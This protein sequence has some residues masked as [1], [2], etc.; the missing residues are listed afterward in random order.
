MPTAL[1]VVPKDGAPSARPI[2]WW[3]SRQ[4]ASSFTQ[5]VTSFGRVWPQKGKFHVVDAPSDS[6]NVNGVGYL[7]IALFDPAGRFVI[8]FGVS[9]SSSDDN[10]NYALRFPQTREL[11]SDFTPNFVFGGATFGTV[12][13]TVR[14]SFYKGPGHSGDI[15]GKLGVV[16]AAD[17][18][19][20]QAIGPGNVQFGTTV[21]VRRGEFSFWAGRVDD[22]VAATR[23]M[24]VTSYVG[25]G[26]ASRNIA[27]NLSGG[28]PVFALVVPTNATAKVFRAVSDTT[29]RSTVDAN[30]V[31]N[32]ITAMSPN[33]ITVGS[34]LNASGVTY[35]VWTIRTGLVTP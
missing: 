11:A 21:D 6:V 19:R 8:P 12:N 35:D 2:W 24:A 34:A 33:Q 18:D 9:K 17:A 28:T 10:Y 30:P 22:G 4:G 25:D 13:D 14:A 27:L 7:A 15:T 16:Q 29:G 3:A 23:L 26:T 32:S 5:S 1:I 31:A 20:I